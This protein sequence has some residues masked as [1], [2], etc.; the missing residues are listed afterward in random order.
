MSDNLMDELNAFRF[1]LYGNPRATGLNELHYM[2]L[3][4]ETD[5]ILD[6]SKSIDFANLF[7]ARATH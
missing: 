6:A 3:S 5:H 7:F 1:A 2:K 4:H